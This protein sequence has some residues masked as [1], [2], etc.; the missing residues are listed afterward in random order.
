MASTVVSEFEGYISTGGVMKLLRIS[1][2]TVHRWVKEKKL[3]P[4]RFAYRL[5]YKK[6]DVLSL[7]KED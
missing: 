5:L 2:S 7:L 4:I 3:K 1:F 6:K